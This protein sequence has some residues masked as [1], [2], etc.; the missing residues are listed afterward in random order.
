MGA[1][2]STVLLWDKEEKGLSTGWK[3]GGGAKDATERQCRVLPVLAGAVLMALGLLPRL[4][5]CKAVL[6]S[7]CLLLWQSKTTYLGLQRAQWGETTLCHGVIRAVCAQ[8]R[9]SRV[10]LA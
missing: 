4:E 6:C 7:M 10:S 1:V 3:G 5:S 9:A 2:S 8:H